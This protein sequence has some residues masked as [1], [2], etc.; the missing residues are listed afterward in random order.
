VQALDTNGNG[1][2]D[3][4]EITAFAQSQ[5][6]G[7]Q[8]VLA[9]FKELDLNGDGELD[10]SEIGGLLQADDSQTQPETKPASVVT[11]SRTASVASSPPAP[12]TPRISRNPTANQMLNKPIKNVQPD[13]ASLPSLDIKLLDS[14][15][16]Q[17]AGSVVARSLAQRAQLLLANSR[18]DRKRAAEYEQQARALRANA[19][20]L[21]EHISSETQSAASLATNAIAQ[22]SVDDVKRLQDTMTASLA[23]AKE[24]SDRAREARANV[25]Q[26]WASMRSNDR[27]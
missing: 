5:G 3:K 8:E 9:D 26:V 10:A 15:V 19:T 17:Q 7:S 11:P 14:R 16:Q 22:K 12:V 18:A 24:H 6:L 2:V 25:Q 23:A 13:E 20:A 27:V 1:K 21:A 4:N